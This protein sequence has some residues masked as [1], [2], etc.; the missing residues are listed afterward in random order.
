MQIDRGKPG[1]P[2]SAEHQLRRS[3]EPIGAYS[4]DR[5]R[6]HRTDQVAAG[7]GN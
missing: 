2:R 1:P 6:K 3:T 5:E 4:R 7:I